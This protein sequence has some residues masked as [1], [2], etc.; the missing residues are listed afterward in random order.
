MTDSSHS[1]PTGAFSCPVAKNPLAHSLSLPGSKSLTNRELVLASIAEGPST[2]HAPLHARDTSLMVSALR[3]L[4][5]DI[6]DVAGSAKY[7]PDLAITPFFS[8]DAAT[9]ASEIVVDCGLAGTVMRFVPPIALLC[10]R[11]V[12][13]IGDP[14]AGARPMGP[15]IDA[16]RQLGHNVDDDGRQTLPFTLT[17][18]PQKSGTRSRVLIDAS[19]SSQFVSGLLLAAPRFP[20][21]L[22]IEHTGQSLPSLPHIDMTIDVL[23]NRGVVVERPDHHVFDVAPQPVSQRPVVIEPDLSNAAPFLAAAVVAG[24][25]VTVLEWPDHTTQVGALVPEL[26]EHFGATISRTATTVTVSAPGIAAGALPGVSL[27][28]HEA[29]ELAPTFISLSVFSRSPSTFSGISHLRGHE[30]DRI[31]ALVANIRGIGGVAEETPDGIIVTPA[32]LRGGVWKA[33]GDHRMATSGALVGLGQEGVI[34]DD[35]GQTS[36]TLPEFV[37]LWQA[38]LETTT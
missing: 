3:A 1:P 30:T 11:P 28:L 22:T 37:S 20:A 17:P 29:G 34:V 18:I 12:R 16:L 10:N 9:E 33:W 7:G 23:A 27:D 36:K 15:I 38:M 14:Q 24:G 31:A 2:L 35:I 25:S 26:L 4:G 5:A 32:P 8:R 19:A 21:G 13:F 6:V